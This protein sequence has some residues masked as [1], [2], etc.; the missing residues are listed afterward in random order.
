MPSVNGAAGGSED[1]TAAFVRPTGARLSPAAPT[2]ARFKK[3]LREEVST[4]MPRLLKRSNLNPSGFKT[5]AGF[6]ERKNRF[7]HPTSLK[8]SAPSR[9][10]TYGSTSWRLR[11]RRGYVRSLGRR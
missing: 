6:Q 5:P 9:F 4:V 10:H 2:A 8:P 7:P 1:A 11:R 3:S